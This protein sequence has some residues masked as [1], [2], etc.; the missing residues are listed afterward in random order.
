MITTPKKL[1]RVEIKMRKLIE[2]FLKNREIF[3]KLKGY[4]AKLK[5]N[6]T[7]LLKRRTKKRG[8]SLCNPRT[9]LHPS[10]LEKRLSR[11][12]RESQ[13]WKWNCQSN[14]ENWMTMSHS[15][16]VSMDSIQ[17]RVRRFLL[18]SIELQIHS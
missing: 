1:E 4:F 2:I 17:F 11:Q 3:L 15:S 12:I 5:K 7:P 6:I 18:A 14:K 16:P 10:I 13:K 9:P 8:K